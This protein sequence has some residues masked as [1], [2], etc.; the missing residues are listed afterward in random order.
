MNG[1]QK[2][3]KTDGGKRSYA[4]LM[5]H[6]ERF[7]FTDYREDP[8]LTE[9][10]HRD[11]FELGR[12]IAPFSPF[13]MF[14]SPIERCLQTARGI[15]RGVSD[16]KGSC[17]IAGDI[18]L[19]GPSLF[20]VDRDKLIRALQGNEERYSGFRQEAGI[21]TGATAAEHELFQVRADATEVR[22]G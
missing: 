9:K 7:S 8:V 15:C 14:H 3:M 21:S 17:E 16:K 22:A 19:L 10:G 11:A 6:A 13:R 18:E 2:I 12:E 5:R 1:L 4:V 20:I